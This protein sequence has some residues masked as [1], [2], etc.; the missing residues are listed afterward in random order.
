MSPQGRNLLKI[1]LV[2]LGLFVLCVYS[3]IRRSDEVLR[4]KELESRAAKAP[5][6]MVNACATPA[7]VRQEM[8]IEADC[9]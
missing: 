4:M 8:H 7:K 3:L 6:T 1:S 9:P 5:I 2:V